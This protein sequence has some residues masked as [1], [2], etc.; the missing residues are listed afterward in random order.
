MPF[1]TQG[2]FHEHNCEVAGLRAPHSGSESLMLCL[3]H[4]EVNNFVFEHVLCKWSP[5]GQRGMCAIGRRPCSMHACCSLMPCLPT[6][7]T[8]PLED[9]IQVDSWCLGVQH[10]S[11]CKVSMLLPSTEQ[12]LV[13]QPE[14]QLGITRPCSEHSKNAEALT[15]ECYSSLPYSC[16]FLD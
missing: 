3:H 11:D 10:K 7:F 5:V 12:T 13:L 4:L 8:R 14:S 6:A 1:Y 9:R 2:W 16:Y 15:K